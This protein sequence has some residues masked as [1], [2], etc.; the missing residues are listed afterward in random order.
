[1]GSLVFNLVIG[2]CHWVVGSSV[3]VADKVLLADVVFVAIIYMTGRLFNW[4][5][6]VPVVSKQSQWP[7]Y[8]HK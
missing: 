6:N 7:K 3:Y 2:G 5:I 4:V 8:S 1:M